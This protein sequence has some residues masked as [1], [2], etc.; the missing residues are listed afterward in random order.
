MTHPE[1]QEVGTCWFAQPYLAGAGEP[2]T[3]YIIL[4]IGKPRP[5]KVKLLIQGQAARL[6][7]QQTAGH[8]S[9]GRNYGPSYNFFA[10][11]A[12]FYLLSLPCC[13]KLSPW[14]VCLKAALLHLLINLA[15]LPRL[16]R[17]LFSA[18]PPSSPGA[19]GEN[20]TG[21]GFPNS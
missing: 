16:S 17:L 20:G 6:Y 5:R 12:P 18:P 2:H 13:S 8:A 7:S 9:T 11:D 1:A 21:T 14:L 15:L 4:R 19:A 10:F 3:E